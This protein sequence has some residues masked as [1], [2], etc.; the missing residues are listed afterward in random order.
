[1][2]SRVRR[3]AWRGGASATS[4]LACAASGWQA[5]SHHDDKGSRCVKG[6][7]KLDPEKLAFTGGVFP[8]ADQVPT[9]TVGN[10][11]YAASANGTLVYFATGAANM[12][13]AWVDRSGKRLSNLAKPFRGGS[14]ALSP[15]AQHVALFHWGSGESSYAEHMGLRCGAGDVLALYLRSQPGAQFSVV[16]GRLRNCFH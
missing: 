12:Q 7:V 10:E 3:G 6:G 2:A 8:V 14:P 9:R 1:M 11:A 15:D 4:G 13:L 5:W 16:A